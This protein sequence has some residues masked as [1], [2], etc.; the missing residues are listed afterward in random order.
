MK[1]IDREFTGISTTDYREGS[2]IL[3][4]K[5]LEWTSFDV[6]NKIRHRL[7]RYHKLK[8]IKVGHNGTL[9][10]LATGLLMIF[11]GKYTKRIPEEENHDKTYR[12]LIKLGATT[13]SLDRETEEHM[14]RDYGHIT[15]Q[16]IELSLDAMLGEQ[17]QTIPFYSAAK[18]K[19]V[20]LYRLAREGREEVVKRKKVVFHRFE[21]HSYENGF[22]DLTVRCGK[23]T[24]IRSLA[25]DLGDSLDTSAYLYSLRRTAI[26][27][28][29]VEQALKV[30]SFCN[31]IEDIEYS[32]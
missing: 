13:P 25:R 27:Q 18:H 15:K 31:Q 24:Y 16:Q 19:G 11:T 7:K 30:E 26:G 6:V 3:I 21:L 8:K 23:G 5:D 4:D 9:D 14:F 12:A 2:I 1:I 22:I 10:P 32:S 28:F 29:G 17:Q 20:P